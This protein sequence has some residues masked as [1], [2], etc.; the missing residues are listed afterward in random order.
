MVCDRFVR[1]SAEVEIGVVGHVDDSRAVGDSAVGYVKCI[2]RGESVADCRFHVTWK[3]VVTVRRV[4]FEHESAV[5]CCND[6]IYLILPSCW[7]A[8][9]AVA[10]VVLRQSDAVAVNHHS[11]LIDAVGVAAYRSSEVS[12]IVF[13]EI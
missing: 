1:V 12:L 6:V 11:S 9:Q 13:R 8:M 3:I 10:E 7:T 4:H 5:I 2:V